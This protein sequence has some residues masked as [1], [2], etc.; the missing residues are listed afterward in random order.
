MWGRGD[1][2]VQCYLPCF[3]SHSC[4]PTVHSMFSAVARRHERRKWRWEC[5]VPRE[6]TWQG[7]WHKLHD[8]ELRHLYCLPNYVVS[9]NI[10]GEKRKY[11]QAWF[12][13]R[14]NDFSTGSH[15]SF[16]SFS[17]HVSADSGQ[18][19]RGW[20]LRIESERI[21][22]DRDIPTP[23]ERLLG[24]QFSLLELVL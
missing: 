8:G 3:F 20:S 4:S 19:K 6:T 1:T 24:G 18:G 17:I 12:R 9:P 10:D 5:L 13:Q 22:G 11:N 14:R 15:R 16:N 2:S 21:D 7:K 23:S